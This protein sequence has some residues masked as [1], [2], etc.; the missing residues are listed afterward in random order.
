MNIKLDNILNVERFKY[1]ADRGIRVS[2]EFILRYGDTYYMLHTARSV[3]VSL[4]DTGK[5][6]E[7]LDVRKVDALLLRSKKLKIGNKEK[8]TAKLPPVQI[9]LPELV[10]WPKSL[11]TSHTS[12]LYDRDAGKNTKKHMKEMGAYFNSLSPQITRNL[13]KIFYGRPDQ[14]QIKINHVNSAFTFTLN[15]SPNIAN[16]K[17]KD[18][19]YCML[20]F[21]PTAYGPVLILH[22]S[23][24]SS[25][26]EEQRL[27]RMVRSTT[28][29]DL[30]TLFKRIVLTLRKKYALQTKAVLRTGSSK[31]NLIVPHKLTKNLTYSMVI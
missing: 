10:Q 18:Y 23:V 11:P 27:R 28:G 24:E 1:S 3:Y 13:K 30:Y 16:I 6:C 25:A 21:S 15:M 14:E 26:D 9:V 20:R 5:Q 22:M 31:S 19:L 2:A 7:K 29:A 12:A 4:L 17:Q 8:Q